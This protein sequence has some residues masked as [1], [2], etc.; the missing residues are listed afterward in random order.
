MQ[1]TTTEM[2]L[3]NLFDKFIAFKKIKNL[4]PESIEYYEKCYH[5]FAEHYNGSLPCSGITK[6]VVLSLW[7]DFHR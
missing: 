6:D 4:S 1:S 3:E 7:E 2:A 5:F